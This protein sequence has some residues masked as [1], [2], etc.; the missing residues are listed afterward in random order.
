MYWN[1]RHRCQG[2]YD[3]NHSV[4]ALDRGTVRS[5]LVRV[6]KKTADLP[7]ANFSGSGSALVSAMGKGDVKDA[8]Q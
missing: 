8:A 3:R 6:G 2:P 7:A 4:G 1:G 5:V